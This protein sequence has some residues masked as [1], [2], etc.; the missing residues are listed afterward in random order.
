MEKKYF[1]N[2]VLW[3]QRDFCTLYGQK[4]DIDNKPTLQPSIVPHSTLIDAP[5][6]LRDHYYGNAQRTNHL[7]YCIKLKPV[8]HFNLQQNLNS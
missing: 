7:G 5:F 2:Y 6:W 3:Y 8:N 1:L 4:K